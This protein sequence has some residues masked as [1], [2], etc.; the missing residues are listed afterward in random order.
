MPL[1]VKL[2][3]ELSC[4]VKLAPVWRESKKDNKESK[5]KKAN[6]PNGHNNLDFEK[7]KAPKES[8]TTITNT[9]WQFIVDKYFGFK[10][11]NFF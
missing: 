3:E 1:D 11:S 8:R 9:K 2:F 4:H 6:M 7:I 10:T 5:W